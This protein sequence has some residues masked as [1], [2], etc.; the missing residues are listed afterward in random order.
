MDAL[1]IRQPWIDKI[2]ARKKTW[3]IR[4]RS[5]E[6]RGRIALVESGTGSV[7]G[8]ADL[9]DVHG[10]LTLK[11]YIAK[12]STA[13]LSAAEAREGLP[14]SRTYAWVLKRAKR[15]AQPVSYRHPQGAVIWVRLAPNVEKAIEHQLRERP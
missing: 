12:A 6:K 10:P 2:F 8:V 15:L 13:G 3:E 11:D 1:L 4:S 14:Y 7:V 9:I 5:T